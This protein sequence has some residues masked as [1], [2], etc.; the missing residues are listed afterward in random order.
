M[1]WD[2]EHG[3]L[4][5]I[6]E[7]VYHYLSDDGFKRVEIHGVTSSFEIKNIKSIDLGY[8]NEF[9]MIKINNNITLRICVDDMDDYFDTGISFQLTLRNGEFF[10]FYY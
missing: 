10:I 9:F 1:I 4:M 6:D 3:R 8:E 7:I 2:I 5:S